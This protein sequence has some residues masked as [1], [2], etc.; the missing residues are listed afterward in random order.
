LA[1]EGHKA[2]DIISGGFGSCFARAHMSA[3]GVGCS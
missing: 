3:R 1:I 2:G